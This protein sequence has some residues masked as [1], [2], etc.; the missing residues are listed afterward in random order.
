[1]LKELETLEYPHTRLEVIRG[2]HCP[3]ATSDYQFHFNTLVKTL[4]SK[5]A[6]Q[7]RLN[8]LGRGTP[9]AY[10]AFMAKHHPELHANNQ[11]IQR[12]LDEQA[13]NTRRSESL[14]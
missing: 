2:Q 7:D 9:E 1:M 3:A 6:A 13:R 11:R 10:T 5:K 8:Y 4:G 14:E 12:A